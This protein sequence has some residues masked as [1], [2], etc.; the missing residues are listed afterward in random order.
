MSKTWSYK[1]LR[2]VSKYMRSKGFMTFDEMCEQ[3]EDHEAKRQYYFAYLEEIAECKSY[4]SLLGALMK[5]FDLD[6]ETARDIVNDWL[7]E[8]NHSED[9]GYG[10]CKYCRYDDNDEYSHPCDKCTDPTI[11]KCFWEAKD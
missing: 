10:N 1:E 4:S 2:E 8:N 3:L 5:E 7:L 6:Q 11:S 9:Y